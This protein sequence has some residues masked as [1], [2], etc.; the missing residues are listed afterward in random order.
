MVSKLGALAFVLGALG[1]SGCPG[2]GKSDGQS[3]GKQTP[4][5]KADGGAP[6]GS[7]AAT[8]AKWKREGTLRYQYE[9]A[10]PK[11]GPKATET[12]AITFEAGG[13][14]KIK[15]ASGAADVTF[16]EDGTIVV[17]AV[18][19]PEP[20]PVLPAYVHMFRVGP[21]AG[22]ALNVGGDATVRYPADADIPPTQLT[23]QSEVTM[24][25]TKLTGDVAQ[26]DY[27]SRY[28]VIDNDALEAFRAEAEGIGAKDEIDAILEGSADFRLAGFG[29]VEFDV[30]KGK[31]LTASY[32]G[33]GL[34]LEALDRE[35]LSNHEDAIHY[36]LNLQ[37]S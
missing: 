31:M 35:A 2:S 11:T 29:E 21:G 6:P 4:P 18:P 26:Y 23:V 17:K 19:E 16:G 10:R 3:G 22:K 9:G 20:R 32:T 15:G 24:T 25:L 36:T 37:G 30:A 8:E 28:R 1:A 14:A 33:A 27:E 12:L 5:P 7:G 34:P 13:D